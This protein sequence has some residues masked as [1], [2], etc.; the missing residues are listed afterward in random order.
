MAR[1]N[2]DLQE[3]Q[4]FV[5]VAERASFRAAAEDLNLSQ[6]ALSR[7]IDKLEDLLGARLLERTT[8]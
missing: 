3:L 6:P 1:I 4:A 5:A 2:F 7:R 8:R